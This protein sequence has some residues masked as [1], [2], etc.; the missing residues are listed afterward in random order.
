MQRAAKPSGDL[1]ENCRGA[2]AW[3]H[4]AHEIHVLPGE[5]ERKIKNGLNWV[6][7][8]TKFLK[9]LYFRRLTLS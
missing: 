5:K 2:G 9:F 4:Q 7:R 1:W 6:Y 8:E 3:G